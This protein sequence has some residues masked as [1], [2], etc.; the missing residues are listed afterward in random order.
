MHGDVEAAVQVVAHT[1][2]AARACLLVAVQHPRAADDE[3][4]Y[5]GELTVATVFVIILCQLP[6]SR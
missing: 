5:E 2:R 1:G 3:D 4:A 6:V